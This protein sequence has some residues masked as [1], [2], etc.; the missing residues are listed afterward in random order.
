MKTENM[1]QKAIRLPV[2]IHN[3]LD[4]L[5]KSTG[6][7]AAFYMREAIVSH[8]EDLED[9]YASEK[10]LTEIREGKAKLLDLKEF[11]DRVDNV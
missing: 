6:R 3:R 8:I 11:W 1:V 10:A 7:T 5:A 4:E 9:Y 2:D